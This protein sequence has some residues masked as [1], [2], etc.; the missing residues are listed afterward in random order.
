VRQPAE[1]AVVE[2]AQTDGGRGFASLEALFQFLREQTGG[3]SE[4]V[5]N[6]ES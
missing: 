4:E 1:V 3:G 5:V 6:S 2:S